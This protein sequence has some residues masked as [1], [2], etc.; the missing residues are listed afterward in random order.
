MNRSE[1]ENRIE[2]LRKQIDHH[3]YL[4]YVLSK[5]EITDFEYDILLNELVTL[6]KKFPEL[7]DDNSPTKRI[8]SDINKDFVQMEHRYPMLSLGNTYSKEELI[9]FDNRVKKVIGND[10]EYVAELKYDGVAISLNYENGRLKHALTRGDGEKGD[11]VTENV[12]TIR[13][14]PLQLRGRDYPADFEI[15]GEIFIPRKQFEKMNEQRI[16]AGEE[17]FANPRN[18]ASG[19]LKILNSS[20]VAKRP[21]DCFLYHILGEDLPYNSHYENLVK[22][23]DWGFKVPDYLKKVKGI[24]ELFD[25]ISYWDQERKKLPFDTDGVVIKVNSYT[26]Q[27]TLGFT[28]K[29]PRWAIAYKFQAEQAV[30]RLLSI[31]LQVGRTGTITPVANLE[32][33]FLAGTTVKRATLHNADQIKLLDIRVGDSVFIEKGGEI[34]PK[35]TG[36][37]YTERKP[38]TP[39]YSFPLNCP[40][41]HT[42]LV[43]NEGEATHYCPNESGCPPQIKGRIEHFISRKAMDI[44]AAEATIDLLY[45]NGLIKDVADLYSLT[46]D[47]VKQLERFADKSAR[48]L[49][50]SIESSKNVSFERVLYALGIRYVGETVAKKLAKHFISL[51]NLSRASFED[52]M[53]VEEVGD[54]IAGSIIEYFGNPVHIDIILRLKKAGLKFAL[55]YED[56][57]TIGENL[58]NLTFVIS[59]TFQNHSR[60]ELK[61]LITLHGGKN[62][63]SVSSSTN[64]LLAGENAGPAKL[65]KARTLKI[66]VISENDFIDMINN[67]TIRS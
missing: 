63:S 48:N 30:T 62:A 34:I 1:A 29:S 59:G 31:D 11:L 15:R 51:D 9:D 52:L 10:F 45:K 5:P 41:C 27:R 60:E 33:V 12:R 22:S 36:V 64:Y 13:S 65:D 37:D 8:G 23:R 16:V 43:R 18:A 61:E 42:P 35:I 58:K 4:Y 14:I 7:S 17:P 54:R 24:E 3:N 46:E 50:A 26:Q 56:V 53:L 44:G 57:Q 2:E 20:I 47:Q 40:A 38:G 67:P 6:E 49:I 39:P 66:Q 21:L 25:F 28:A 32:P 19:T 55:A